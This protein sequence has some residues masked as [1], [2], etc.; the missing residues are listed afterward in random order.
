M[1]EIEQALTK[2]AIGALRHWKL[3]DQR[4]HLIKYRENAVFRVELADGGTAALR[5]HRSGYHH[6]NALASELAWMADLRKRGVSVPEP[7]PTI[8]GA[9][10]ARLDEAPESQYAD[11]IGWVTGEALGASGQPLKRSRAS[12]AALFE[13]IGRQMARLHDAA[14]RFAKP[15]D[16]VRPAWDAAGILG[17]NPFWGRFWDF[18]GLGRD[19]GA[20]LAQLRDRLQG[21]LASIES[22]L[23][24]GLIHAD[25]VRENILVDG[26]R[27]A[28]IDFDDCGFGFRLFDL[29][30]TLLRNR[31]EPDYPTIRQSL[32]DGYL[33]GRPAMRPAAATS[34]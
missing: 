13:A 24:F 26:G 21:E 16:F 3:P 8:D 12:L 17:E 33:S 25:L 32:L 7:I 31:D 27:I 19:D 28:F 20:F 11:L 15:F 2:R 10:L 14:D 22:R 18:P 5:L 4:P 29:A 30:T 23:D 34:R 6:G 1:S 9:L